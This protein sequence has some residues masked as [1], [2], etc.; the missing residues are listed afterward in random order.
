VGVIGV[1]HVAG[2]VFVFKDE[3]GFG[4]SLG[5]LVNEEL[6]ITSFCTLKESKTNTLSLLY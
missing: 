1:V 5:E 3:C 4:T 2:V 6:P